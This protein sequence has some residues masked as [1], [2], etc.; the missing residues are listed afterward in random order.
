MKNTIADEL[1]RFGPIGRATQNAGTVITVGV[2]PYPGPPGSSYRYSF[3]SGRP[4]WLDDKLP[5]TVITAA[6]Y[7]TGATA[8]T[9]TLLRP[10]NFA[11]ITAAIAAGGTSVSI[12]K[13][14]GVYSTN[15]RYQ[16]PGGVVVNSGGGAVPGVADNPIAAGDYVAYQL[17][18]GRW[19]FD[20]IASGTF[21]GGNLLLTTGVPNVT[22]AGVAAQTP[23]FYFGIS[24]DVDPATGAAHP[25]TLTIANATRANLF[26]DDI[27]GFGNALHPGDPMLLYSNNATDAGSFEGVAGYYA[28][29]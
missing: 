18:D 26:D 1:A 25:G 12:D 24:S 10:L 22:G 11:M 21:A 8:H 4:T 15:C 23:L 13:D 14:P 19:V 17:L 9:V 6:L 2:S 20:T 16:T 5:R 29:L 3:A 27:L 7:T 28:R